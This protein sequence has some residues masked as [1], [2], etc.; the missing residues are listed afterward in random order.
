VVANDRE[1]FHEL[2]LNK[3][4]RK[5]GNI[6]ERYAGFLLKEIKRSTSLPL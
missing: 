5:L 3:I 2:A 4:A 6:K 1:A